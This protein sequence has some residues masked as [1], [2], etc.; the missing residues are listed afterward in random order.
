MRS[1]EFRVPRRLRRLLVTITTLVSGA[2]LVLLAPPA[3]ACGCGGVVAG[4]G[5]RTTVNQEVAL[6]TGDGAT[7]TVHMQ[8]SMQS[9]AQDLGLLVPTPAP[10]TVARGD[11]DIFSNLTDITRPRPVE[12]FHL[13]GPTVLF[14]SDSDSASGTQAGAPGAG[15]GVQAISTVDLGPMEATNLRADDP[16]ALE[17]WLAAHHYQMS[18]GLAAQVKPYVDEQWAFVAVRLTQQGKQL[19]GELP[20]LV[21]TF[22]SEQLVYPMRMSRAA[23]HSESVLTYVLGEHR[24]QRVDPTADAGDRAE[25][26]FAGT[27]PADE[28]H[29]DGLRKLLAAAP[30]VTAVDQYLAEPSTEIASDFIFNRAATDEAFHSTYTVDTYGIPIDIA[31]IGLL[32]L[33][34]VIA[35]GWWFFRRRRTPRAATPGH[36]TPRPGPGTPGQPLN[37]E[38]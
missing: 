23:D 16:A 12:N 33:V 5:H 38:Q 21:M 25:I 14:D 4:P 32:L 29:S 19:R 2:A 7:E 10:A 24:V 30:Y 18:E 28:I 20:P 34:G 26:A 3:M 13:F 11:A 22:A 8:L 15:A 27:V 31:I 37:A 35:L 9:D 6:L 1:H 17:S 36:T